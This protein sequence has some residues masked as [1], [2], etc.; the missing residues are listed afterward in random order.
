MKLKGLIPLAT[1]L[2]LV[3]GCNQGDANLDSGARIVGRP[4]AAWHMEESFRGFPAPKMNS[5]GLVARDPLDIQRPTSLNFHETPAHEVIAALMTRF[6]CRVTLTQQASRYIHAKDVRITA[7]ASAV[8][9]NLAFEVLRGQMEAVGLVVQEAPN[10]TILGRPHFLIDR[11][12]LR[13]ST[14]PATL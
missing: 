1:L 2:V 4:D 11:S 10:S 5:R 14:V 6:R 8:P 13:A 3:S 12:R 7:R 9:E